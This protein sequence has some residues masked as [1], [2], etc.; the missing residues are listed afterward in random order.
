MKNYNKKTA[1]EYDAIRSGHL[2]ERRFDIIKRLLGVVNNEGINQIAEVGSG[3]GRLSY[4]ISSSFTDKK[5]DSFEYNEGFVDYARENFKRENLSYQ[6]LDIEKSKLPKEYD[7]II[8]VDLL[9]HL[10]DL[11]LSVENIKGSLRNGGFWIIIE[12]NIFN[13]YIFLFQ[14]LAKNEALFRPKKTE[15]FFE[16]LSILKKFYAFLIPAFIRKPSS[17]LKLWERSF[18]NFF[19]CGGSVIYLLKKNGN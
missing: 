11:R 19:C 8:T 15:R 3:A 9:H 2:L 1:F 4:L 16:G 14:L 18:E 7:V 5:V 10:K 6:K 13:P 12:P 17:V